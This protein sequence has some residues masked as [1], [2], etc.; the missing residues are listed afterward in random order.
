MR[1]QHHSLSGQ[2]LRNLKSSISKLLTIKKRAKSK[3]NKKEK[4]SDKDVFSL[5]LLGLAGLI[6]LV[7]STLLAFWST[8]KGI[9]A[10]LGYAE[11]IGAI[12]I[13]LS[14]ILYNYNRLLGFIVTLFGVFP[15]IFLFGPI[16]ESAIGLEGIL[17]STI[18]I[19][20]PVLALIGGI[21]LFRKKK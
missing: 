8:G 9:G 10:V 3:K 13:W 11:L 12:V 5:A 19:I 7:I 20:G 17:L 1:C 18:F 21:R 16:V 4:L 6:M 14:I 2:I 15:S